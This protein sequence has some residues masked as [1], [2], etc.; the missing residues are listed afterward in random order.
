M[1]HT[2]ISLSALIAAASLVTLANAT[3]TTIMPLRLLEDGASDAMI[4]LFGASYFAG[5]M[6]GC[7]TEPPKILRIGYIRA[8]AAS[9]AICTTLAIVMDMTGTPAVWLVLRFFTG[10]AV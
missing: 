7:F 8:F 5:F 6:A 2:L 1:R 3:M 10:V 4:A 9:A